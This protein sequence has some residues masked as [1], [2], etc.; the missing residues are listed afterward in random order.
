LASGYTLASFGF[1]SFFTASLAGSFFSSFLAA[2]Y[3]LSSAFS[4]AGGLFMGVVGYFFSDFYHRVKLSYL[5]C[6][7][8]HLKII[9]R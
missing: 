7:I 1:S 5:P 9:F 2:A 3:L 6:L 8:K 4:V